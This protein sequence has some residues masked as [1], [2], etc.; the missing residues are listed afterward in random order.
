MR[1]ISIKDHRP[2][3]PINGGVQGPI[4]PFYAEVSKIIQLIT[5]GYTVMHVSKDGKEIR[6]TMANTSEDFCPFEKT[7]E[8]E[9]TR[10]EIAE[11]AEK[12]RQEEINKAKTE[13][14]ENKRK[15]KEAE[16]QAKEKA[17]KEAEAEEVRLNAQKPKGNQQQRGKQQP[18]NNSPETPVESR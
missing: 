8:E 9:A 14:L 4:R 12:K 17:R 16:E 6:A 13:A 10:K 15:M 3:Y 2:I 5:S 18:R 11:K 1:K 7:A